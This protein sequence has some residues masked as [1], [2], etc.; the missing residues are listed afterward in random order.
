MPQ[1][2][3]ARHSRTGFRLLCIAHHASAF[4]VVISPDLS[5]EEKQICSESPVKRWCNTYQATRWNLFIKNNRK[6]QKWLWASRGPPVA[7]SPPPPAAK[8]ARMPLVGLGAELDGSCKH[9]KTRVSGLE[10]SQTSCHP[11]TNL[12]TW[13]PA[14]DGHPCSHR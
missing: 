4:Y 11:S 6:R 10:I 9:D 13:L 5:T 14:T 8:P 7:V 1:G 3:I 12:A 2:L